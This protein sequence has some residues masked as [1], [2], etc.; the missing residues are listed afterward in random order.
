MNFLQFKDLLGVVTSKPL[1]GQDAQ[2]QMVPQGRGRTDLQSIDRDR[3]KQ[4]A[5]AA[6]FYEKDQRPHLILTKRSEY[7]GVHSG[8]ISFPGGRKEQEDVDFAQ[9]ALRETCEEIGIPKKQIELKAQLTSVYIPP[10]NFLVFPY[11]GLLQ[12]TPHFIPQEREVRKILSL[13][14]NAFLDPGSIVEKTIPIN[15]AK[16]TV[17][18][19][20]INGH[21][22][23]G[24][25][26]MMISELKQM[27][28]KA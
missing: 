14:F 18:A 21:I 2:Y 3:V 13:D 4:A 5:V 25:T 10:S 20:D 24:A 17:P 7:P 6:L 19:F 8:Q 26:A 12:Q 15:H 1:P 9:T 27:F 16:L 22:I 28:L 23:W 11:V